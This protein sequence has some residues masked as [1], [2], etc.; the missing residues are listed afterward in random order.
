[1]ITKSCMFF[2]ISSSFI[3][4][5]RRDKPNIT[6]LLSLVVPLLEYTFEMIQTYLHHTEDTQFVHV[7]SIHLTEY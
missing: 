2:F 4:L 7:S 3:E 1:M 6:Y 5:M